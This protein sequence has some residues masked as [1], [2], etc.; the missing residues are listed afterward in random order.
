MANKVL[1]KLTEIKL[2]DLNK[3]EILNMKEDDKGVLKFMRHSFPGR[4][5]ELNIKGKFVMW[6]P[7]ID[8][9]YSR[10]LRR[11]SKVTVQITLQFLNLS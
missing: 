1:D 4:L 2:P 8:F 9:S 7:S 6:R 11:L 3:I 10:L 5:N